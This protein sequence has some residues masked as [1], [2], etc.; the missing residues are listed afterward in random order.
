L[1]RGESGQR[2]QIAGELPAGDGE[3][4][5]RAQPCQRGL[6]AAELALGEVQRSERGEVCQRGKVAAEMRAPR[7][8][9]RFER[10]ETRERG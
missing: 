9:E 4:T 3:L 5:E 10:T 7:E 6:I 8:I 2:R 1:E